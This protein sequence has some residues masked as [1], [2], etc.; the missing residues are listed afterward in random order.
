MDYSRQA[1]I[2]SLNKILPLNWSKNNPIDIIG[3]AAP[4]DYKKVLDIIENDKETENII[5]IL[6]PQ[7]TS[8]PEKVAKLLNTIKKP[9]FTC[10]IGG[11]KINEAKKILDKNKII[12]FSEPEQLCKTISKI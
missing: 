6:T 5:L 10:F 7:H 3:D 9:L 12:N 1:S 4:E 11:E 2:E 8:Q